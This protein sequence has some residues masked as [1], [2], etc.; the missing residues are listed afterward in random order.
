M[1]KLIYSLVALPLTLLGACSADEGT[2][3][4]TDSYPAV[5]VYSYQ[6]SDPDLNPDN[7]VTVRFATNNA[8][9]E[10]YYLVEDAAQAKDFIEKNG[11]DAYVKRIIENGEKFSV[12]GAT[13]TDVN[14]IDKH[15]EVM[16]SAVA[17]NG[18]PGKRNYVTFLGLDW[19]DVI[20][21]TFYIQQSFIPTQSTFATLQ[22]CTTDETL[23]RLNNAFGEGY[24]MKIQL[25]DAYG[26]DEDG[27]Y[28]LFRIPEAN[29]P[30]TFD[31]RGTILPIWVEDI[32]YWQ[33]N[34]SFVTD[35]TGYE[36]GMYEDD[37]AFF[38][39]VW[40]AGNAG[41]LSYTTPSFFIPNAD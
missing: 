9:R 10:V 14:L 21:G 1:N 20:D 24:A 18:N 39:I 26:E 12:E 25:L 27:K 5:T 3:P 8:A 30:F 29:T 34:S 36:N 2:E 15:G 19:E 22:I 31:N 28:R 32:G 35:V 16:I 23:Y 33:G 11:E 4:G 6:P 7:D 37:S 41:Y 13:S 40:M 38:R 17:S